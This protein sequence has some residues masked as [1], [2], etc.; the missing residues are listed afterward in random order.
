MLELTLALLLATAVTVGEGGIVFQPAVSPDGSKV[1]YAADEDGQV[2]IYVVAASGEGMRTRIASLGDGPR[3]HRLATRSLLHRPWSPNGQQLLYLAAGTDPEARKERLFVVGA[4]GKDAKPVGQEDGVIEN[5]SWLTATTLVYSY[6]ESMKAERVK[7]FVYDVAKGGEA[8]DKYES[9]DAAI[10]DLAPS[11]D[12]RWLALLH[13]SGPRDARARQLR[14]FD[15]KSARETKLD[16]TEYANFLSWSADSTKLLYLDT[17]RHE[18]PVWTAGEPAA[19]PPIVRDLAAFVVAEGYILGL[20]MKGVLSA[21]NVETGDRGKDLGN[22]YVPISAAGGKVALLRQGA[23]GGAV[24]IAPVSKEAIEAGDIG[25]PKPAPAPAPSEPPKAPET[26]ASGSN[27]GVEDGSA[28]PV[29][30]G[31]VVPPQPPG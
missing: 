28:R 25:L 16:H 2:S 5:A 18:V 3:A 19:S 21:Y 31:T 22:D 13:L 9:K 4:D 8:A 20:D 10:A 12:G 23:A 11:P 1:A 27:G 6:R 17:L 24:V 7:I 29:P 26:P 30:A 15:L 14:V